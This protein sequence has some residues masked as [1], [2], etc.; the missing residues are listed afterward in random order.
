MRT[1]ELMKNDWVRLSGTQLCCRV[2][3]YDESGR[4]IGKTTGGGGFVKH[5]SCLS[6]IELTQDTIL[7]TTFWLKK[8]GIFKKTVRGVAAFTYDVP[9]R[10][11]T[12]VNYDTNSTNVHRVTFMHELQQLYRHYVCQELEV[13]MLHSK[14]KEYSK[15]YYGKK[16]VLRPDE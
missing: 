14:R 16:N 6:P 2:C 4:V 3:A 8:K 15:K 12:V 11:L 10:L 5:V 13:D 9:N 1:E 7:C